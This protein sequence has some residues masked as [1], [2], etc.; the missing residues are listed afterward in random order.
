MKKT[1]KTKT[2]PA[3]V[4]PVVETVLVMRTCNADMTAYGGFKWP[5]SGLVEAPDWK[6]IAKCGHGLHGLLWGVGSASH[7][8]LSDSAK[9][10][11][12][13]VAAELVVDLGG[14]VKFPRGEVVFCGDLKGAADYICANGGAG[15]AVVRGTSTSGYDGTST[16]GY[17][18]TST[19]GDRGT[20]T[21]GVSGTAT[22]GDSGTATAGDRGT[23]TA[24][25]RGTA[26][27]GS[28]GTICILY[29]SG[30]RYKSRIA[31]VKD[32]DGDGE[33]E[34]NV[35]YRLNERGEFVKAP[36][37]KKDSK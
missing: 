2:A 9:G 3:V 33:L 32:E 36:V 21:S 31:Q 18:G 17:D 34:P 29:W 15:R 11:V 14:K 25:V 13:R 6:P 5:E 12:V 27:A 8:D 37:G 35:P 28:G 30:K 1:P 20:S 23:A 19:S 24:G 26:T 7:L 10:L 4:A 16:S 22:A